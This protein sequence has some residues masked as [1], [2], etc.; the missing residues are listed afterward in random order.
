VI[1]LNGILN[2]GAGLAGLLILWSSNFTITLGFLV[3]TFSETEAAITAIE[4]VDAMSCLPQEGA[5]YTGEDVVLSASWPERG[6]LEFRNVSLRYRAGLP[7][8]LKD[9]S[10]RISAGE[11]VGIVG[12]SGAGK[13]TITLA[14][15]RLIE[16]ESGSILLDG[17]DL[18]SIGLADVR[19]RGMEIIP[20]NPFLVGG[21]LRECVDPFGQ[22]KDEDILNALKAVRLIKDDD[23]L[24]VLSS[25]VEEGGF[26]FS[27][28]ERQLLNLARAMLSKPVLL[29]LDEAT[30]S[31][32]GETDAF[33]QRML[34]MKFRDTTQI[35]VA[36]RLETIMDSDKI[37]VMDYGC[38][39]EIG[40][41]KI[42][43][44]RNGV[45]AE[46]VDAA[47]PEASQALRAMVKH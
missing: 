10:F 2:I 25:P 19:G 24:D 17:V 23:S 1:S 20:Q 15:F 14:L 45:F 36:H 32:D 8:A 31:I 22:S 13:S 33:L 28:G 39:V 27:V 44:A 38:A 4:R 18:G 35:T 41:P 9:L 7:L 6:E 46:L 37:I 47:G 3:D 16:I 29:C 11:R 26:N 40:S 42:L 5:R 30:A 12:R 34:R 21:T 43:L